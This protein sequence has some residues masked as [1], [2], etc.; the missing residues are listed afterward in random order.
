MKLGGERLIDE[1]IKVVVLCSVSFRDTW[2]DARA[3]PKKANG[4]RQGRTCSVRS[5]STRPFQMFFGV[6]HPR[7][8][9]EGEIRER[10]REGERERGGEIKKR[11][12][13]GRVATD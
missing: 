2:T 4:N 6:D 5:V 12:G 11:R 8:D 13:K 9:A 3:E 10:G 1:T 7:S